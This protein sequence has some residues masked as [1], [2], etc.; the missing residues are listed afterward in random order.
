MWPTQTSL[1]T[2]PLI[3]K[4]RGGHR[5]IG[6]MT[7]LYRV[8]SKARR[9]EAVAWEA[10]HDRPYFAAAAG[11]GPID[12]VHRQAMRQ[13]AA[14]ASGDAAA[15]VLEDLEAFYESIDRARLLSEAHK[16]GFPVAIVRACL[17]AYAA[18]RM[19]TLDKAAARELYPR[20]GVIAGCSFATTLVK[21]FY[22]EYLR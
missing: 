19:L 16:H 20:R 13:E 12:A 22:L 11:A 6:K 14:V 3:G 7:A 5:G 21:L 17:A 9:P 18:P 4:P 10:K 15:V 1:V 8:W 2:M